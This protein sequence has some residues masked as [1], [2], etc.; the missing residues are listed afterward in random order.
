MRAYHVRIHGSQGTVSA[1]QGCFMDE[2]LS[3][4]SANDK[5]SSVALKTNGLTTFKLVGVVLMAASLVSVWPGCKDNSTAVRSTRS[6]RP[7]VASVPSAFRA[8]PAPGHPKLLTDPTHSALWSVARWYA[9]AHRHGQPASTSAAAYYTPKALYVAVNCTGTSDASAATPPAKL[10]LHSCAE[11]WLDSSVKQNGTNFYEIVVAPDGRT[12]QVWHKSGSP[13]RPTAGGKINFN[14]PFASIPW[15]T[16]GLV[17]RAWPHQ[18]GA[19][20]GWS[21][22]V[23]IPLPQ[24]P[25]S[26]GAA[27]QPGSRY[28]INILRYVWRHVGRRAS[29]HQADLFPVAT[30]CQPFAPYRMGRLLLAH[31]PTDGLALSANP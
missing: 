30:G 24:L 31:S 14:H 20:P 15:K 2:T 21:A 3:Q 7:S 11:I 5:V 4:P 27:C 17:A 12:N 26:L 23:R 13:P 6:P 10:W 28:R 18:M 1:R 16:P 25:R 19:T 8:L 9:L 22:V 29:L